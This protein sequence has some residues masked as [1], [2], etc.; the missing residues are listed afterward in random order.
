H[1]VRSLGASIEPLG[2]KDSIHFRRARN[3][4]A[5]SL[6]PFLGKQHRIRAPALEAR[7]MPGRERRDLIEEKQIGEARSPN[8]VAP[9]LELQ[10][11]ADPLARGPAAPAQRPAVAMKAPAAIAEE[12]SARRRRDQFAERIDAVLQRHLKHDPE[13]HVLDPDRGWY[14]F[15]EKIMLELRVAL[16]V[17]RLVHRLGGGGRIGGGEGVL[18]SLLEFAG[19]LLLAQVALDRLVFP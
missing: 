5:V 15:S 18:Q 7:P 16:L 3:S 4:A 9:P 1:L 10:H 6:P 13:K 2:L 17:V 8:V 19:D 11:A 12:H 14:R